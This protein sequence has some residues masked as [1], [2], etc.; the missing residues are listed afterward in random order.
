MIMKNI[1]TFGF[2]SI[3]TMTGL[4]TTSVIANPIEPTRYYPTEVNRA[5]ERFIA[6]RNQTC[7]LEAAPDDCLAAANADYANRAKVAQDFSTPLDAEFFRINAEVY[8]CKGEGVEGY[9]YVLFANENTLA[10]KRINALL[11]PLLP[12]DDEQEPDEYSDENK[13]MYYEGENNQQLTF[14][15]RGY[16][17]VYTKNWIYFYGAAHPMHNSSSQHFNLR[18]GELLTKHDI[19]NDTAITPLSQLCVASLAEQ[20]DMPVAQYEKGFGADVAEEFKS[21]QHWNF[22]TQ[23]ARIEFP[24]YMAGSYADGFMQCEFTYNQIAPFLTSQF[25]TLLSSR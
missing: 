1:R 14:A 22:T 15:S 20:M 17:S 6:Q 8:N 5:Y 21:I 4:T 25:I 3:L 2:L 23:N 9:S 18:T 12:S 7:K 19:F 13:C 11:E 16:L 24:P 10:K